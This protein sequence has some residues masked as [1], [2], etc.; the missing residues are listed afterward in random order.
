MRHRRKGRVLGRSPSHRKA[1]YKNMVKN[2]FLTEDPDAEG[3]PGAAKVKGRVV[4]TLAKAKE[5][6]G[7]A[8]KCITIAC[9]GLAAEEKAAEFGTDAEPQTPEWETWRK[10]DQWRKWANAMAPAVT[11]RRR[12]VQLLSERGHRLAKG[13]KRVVRILFEE[14]APRYRERPGGYTR[15]VRLATPRLGDAGTRAILELVGVRDRVTETAP[16]PS[17]DDASA[18]ESSS[19]E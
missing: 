6:R 13:D 18:A 7:L 10:S 17:F 9:K 11:A 1:L 4:T 3:S 5:V 19:E 14:I 12:I 2:L 8:E 15:V 16:A